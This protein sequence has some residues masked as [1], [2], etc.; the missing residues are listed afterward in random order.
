MPDAA[1]D[2]LDALELH[3]AVPSDVCRVDDTALRFVADAC[4]AD[5]CALSARDSDGSP[6]RLIDTT[7][8]D[9][10]G[11]HAVYP[12]PDSAHRLTVSLPSGASEAHLLTITRGPTAE[13]FSASARIVL[14]AAASSLALA[15]A[16]RS[17]STTQSEIEA[18]AHAV[19]DTVVD[20]IIT[21]DERGTIQSFNDAAERIFGYPRTDAVGQPIHMLMPEPYRSAH[22]GYLRAYHET[23]RRKIIGIGREVTGLRRDGTVFPMYLGVSEVQLPGEVVF[24]GIV[25]DLSEQRRL[26]QEVLRVSDEERRRI[27]QDLHDGLG[28]MLTG[29]GMLAEGAAR[30]LSR[31]EHS[32]TEHV[33]EIADLIREADRYARSL[34]RGLVPVE[35]EQGGLRGALERLT[36]HAER[37]FGVTCALT[38]P[39]GPNADLIEDPERSIH[40]Y[41]I[42]QEAV[43][44]AAQHGRAEHVAVALRIDAQHIALTVSD[45]GV[46]MPDAP[47]EPADQTALRGMGLR[48]MRYR[49]R[50]LGA[51]L[52]IGPAPDG[53]T[54]VSCVLRRDG[55]THSRD[56]LVEAAR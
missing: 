12:V 18:R 52:D 31:A 14:R 1:L 39:D 9:A 50:I 10:D 2:A 47:P 48:I 32:E 33:R 49:A 4:R 53:G 3:L 16:R 55:T 27:G 43:S 21:I 41:R 35:L 6:L 37:L 40:L 36:L 34:A 23:G 25:R 38:Y 8:P 30:R 45:D 24:T 7:D 51:A 42:A 28:Q 44:N 29:V 46:G 15:L 26:E 20:A 11:T 19:L 17:L 22:G 5:A 54:V 56:P 13:P